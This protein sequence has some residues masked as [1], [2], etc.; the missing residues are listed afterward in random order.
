[1]VSGIFK[2]SYMGLMANEQVSETLGMLCA[3]SEHDFE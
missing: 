3:A 2:F 1:V